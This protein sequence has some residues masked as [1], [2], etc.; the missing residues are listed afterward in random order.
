MKKIIG[1]DLGVG[2]IG[3]AVVQ[4]DENNSSENK[5]LGMGS[6]IIPIDS[7]DITEFSTGVAQTKNSKRTALRTARK[8]YFRYTLRRTKLKEELEKK[9]MYPSPEL[10]LL[11]AKELY[12]LRAKAVD[13]EVSLQELGRIWTHLNQK[14]GYRGSLKDKPADKKQGDYIKKINDREAKLKEKD[15]TIGQFFYN[16]LL[17]DDRFTIKKN[18][19]YRESYIQEFNEIVKK[20][21]EYYPDILTDDF[22]NK[23]R[24]EI[25]YYQRPLKS[26]KHLVGGCEFEKRVFFKDGKKQQMPIKVA[27]ISAPIFQMCKL[28]QSINNIEIK[29]KF[30]K[31]PLVLEEAQKQKLFDYLSD[32]EKTKEEEVLKFLELN[33]KEYVT[34]I[35]KHLTGDFTKIAITKQLKEAEIDNSRIKEC[36]SYNPFL[37]DK[38]HEQQPYYRIW[39]ILYSIEDCEEASNALQKHCSFFNKQQAGTILKAK[40]KDGFGSLSHKAI[41]KILPFLQKGDK[42]S[43]A[44]KKAGYNHSNSITKEENIARVLLSIDKLTHVKR[45]SLRNPAVEKVLNQLI[46]LVKAIYEQYGEPDEIRIEL[47]RELKQNAEQRKSTFDKNREKE[48]KNEEVR[49]K[50]IEANI[51]NPSGR[52][53]QKYLLWEEFEGISPYNPE[54]KIGLEEL[55]SAAY[56]V[57]HIIPRSL[58]FDDSFQNKCIASTKDNRD[59]GNKTAF[60]FMQ[61]DRNAEL[62]ESYKSFIDNLRK[63]NKISKAKYDKLMMSAN[64]LPTDFINRQ[65]NETQ[66][67]S[68]EATKILRQVCRNVY[69]TTGSITAYIRH[70]WGYDRIIHDINFS[71]YKQIGCTEVKN[72]NGQDVERIKKW[73]KRKDHRHH[74]VDALVVATTTQ[75]IITNMNTLAAQSTKEEMQA[76]LS[77]EDNKQQ[78]KSLLDNYIIAWRPFSTHVVKE[79]VAHILVSYKKGKRLYSYSRN[80]DT[81]G[82]KRTGKKQLIPR[83][84]LHEETIYGTIKQI[85]KIDIKK[86]D[87]NLLNNMVNK[88]HKVILESYLLEHSNDYKLAFGDKKNR[89][90]F[91][92]KNST[93]KEVLVYEEKIT[94]RC[95]I[96]TNFKNMADIV[97]KRVREKVEDRLKQ[98]GGDSKKA[99]RDIENNPIWLD[100]EKKLCV[101]SAICITTSKTIQEINRGK[102]KSGNNYCFAIYKDEQGVKAECV[103]FFDAFK[104]KMQGQELIPLRNE[105]L[106]S[107]EVNEFFVIGMSERRY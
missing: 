15:E 66:Y 21:R 51:N 94:K 89:A 9:N 92:E 85:E 67:I 34:N 65:L 80:K 68:K 38:E 27:P 56:E 86:M 52:D 106:M 74:A 5:I 76:F 60:D 4:I 6:R 40:L 32:R 73:D 53:I 44:C 96:D 46:N 7:N 45:G 25:I 105:L 81:K 57:E 16:N 37:L 11:N 31:I 10:F 30:D 8:T 63:D 75:G 83:A 2:S 79:H 36:L 39:H 1:L 13:S 14:R 91:L 64:E 72:Y 59:K 77:K 93:L 19:F 55:F 88:N 12:G 41:K 20:Q 70:L 58:L 95:V 101:K 18:I 28:W 84:S 62:F 82:K 97:D 100:E 98:F 48:E 17:K 102:V 78:G 99:F 103:S 54:K 42:Y 26:C 87:S 61:Q 22:V 23:I 90:V 104:R 24:D 3:W 49:R 107:L 50:L 69:V 33:I 71:M 47:A 43:D 29:H 35:R